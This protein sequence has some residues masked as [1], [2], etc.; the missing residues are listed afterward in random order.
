MLNEWEGKGK[1][2]LPGINTGFVRPDAYKI[3]EGSLK[4]KKKFNILFLQFTK[5]CYDYV[6]TLAACARVYEWP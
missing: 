3:Q 6:N 4:E 1:D 5:T 2:R